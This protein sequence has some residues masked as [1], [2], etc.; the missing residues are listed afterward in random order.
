MTRQ[1]TDE[2]TDLLTANR[3]G[4]RRGAGPW[5]FRALDVQARAGR[6]LAILGPNGRG[7]TTLLR[8]LAGLLLPLEGKVMCNCA[9]SYVPQAGGEA[10]TYPVRV[11]VAMGRAR[12]AGVFGVPS[13]KDWQAADAALVAVGMARFAQQSFA[14]L[15]GGERQLV[16]MARAMVAGAR[17]LLL[18]EPAS[19]LDLANQGVILR[20]IRNLAEREGLAIIM[21]TH[22]P[23]HALEAA[24]DVLLLGEPGRHAS[25]TV[26]AAMTGAAL[27]E[28]YGLPV[29]IARR[30]DV[31]LHAAAIL[32]DFGLRRP[33]TLSGDS[34]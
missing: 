31:A 19:A 9:N 11:M 29:T 23:Q 28:L 34:T 32:P 24:D 4:F 2:A 13:R 20:L 18:D 8:V 12:H 22:H 3:L 26:D 10:P 16:L 17:C 21:T 33:N 25:G 15:S 1:K 6:V 5:L 14:L 7:K 27:S 30:G